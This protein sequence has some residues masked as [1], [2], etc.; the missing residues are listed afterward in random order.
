MLHNERNL[1][2]LEVKNKNKVLFVFV[3]FLARIKYFIGTLSAEL[4]GSSTRAVPH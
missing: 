4:M 1:F 2:L 3:F